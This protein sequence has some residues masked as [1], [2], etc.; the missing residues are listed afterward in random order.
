MNLEKIFG[1]IP[2]SNMLVKPGLGF[3]DSSEVLYLNI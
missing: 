1:T 2:V 3:V